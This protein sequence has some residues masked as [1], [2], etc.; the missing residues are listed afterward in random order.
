MASTKISRSLCF[1]LEDGE[2]VFPCTM[3][4]QSTGKHTYRVSKH[5]GNTLNDPDPKKREEE[6]TEAEMVKYVLQLG[7]S[8]RVLKANGEKNIYSPKSKKIVVRICAS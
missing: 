2:V 7:Y 8:T 4:N 3:K 1:L 5:G 6:A